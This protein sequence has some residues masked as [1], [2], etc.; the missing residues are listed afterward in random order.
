M[1][2]TF[3]TKLVAHIRKLCQLSIDKGDTFYILLNVILLSLHG[4][5]FKQP[6][7]WPRIVR[8]VTVSGEGGG[9]SEPRT[10]L[11]Q[12]FRCFASLWAEAPRKSEY[13]ENKVMATSV[14]K[15]G[16]R[17]AYQDVRADTTDTNW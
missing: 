4:N 17:D 3:L 8:D 1:A 9:M 15:E 11:S 7:D 14:D 6:R 13:K 12:A 5:R 2:K 10:I 16:L